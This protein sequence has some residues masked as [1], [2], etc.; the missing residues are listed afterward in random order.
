MKPLRL[1]MPGVLLAVLLTG[2]CSDYGNELQ[3]VREGSIHVEITDAPFPAHLVSAA[4]ITIVKIDARRIDTGRETGPPFEVLFEGE[5]TINIKELTN[6]LT[7]SM[8]VAK[9]PEGTY[10]L[11]RV[12]I[13][14]SS[15]SLK[16]ERTFEVKVPGGARSGIKIF[17]EPVLQVTEAE[18][19]EVLL[20]MDLSQ[21][22]VLRGNTETASGIYGFIFKPVIRAANQ[23][24][25]GTVAGRVFQAGTETQSGIEGAEVSLFAADTLY[26]RS[27]TD[28]EGEYRIMGLRAG[29]YTVSAARE[30]FQ[31]SEHFERT[32]GEG[33][34]A[35]RDFGL[36]PK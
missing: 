6:G 36:L 7:R 30:G 15:L 25:A 34:T 12:F 5:E 11:I 13:S 31:T 26:T 16:D 19:S 22:F 2:S 4:T 8:G 10:D 33:H 3:F 17:P 35:L 32:V 1:L 21:S 20:D 27:F 29:T 18:I 9:V 23:G 14:K 24:F 28:A